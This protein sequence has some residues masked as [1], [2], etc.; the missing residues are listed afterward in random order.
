[1]QGRRRDKSKSGTS[2]GGGGGARGRAPHVP[3][4]QH[5]P[6]SPRHNP[7][8]QQLPVAP[9][10]IRVAPPVAPTH[11]QMEKLLF[12]QQLRLQVPRGGGGGGRPAER[13]INRAPAMAG[14]PKTLL[15]A[16]LAA[17][18]EVAAMH[19]VSGAAAVKP[20]AEQQ[21]TALAPEESPLAQA[22]VLEPKAE[23]SEEAASEA[24]TSAAAEAEA[25]EE[26]R[27]KQE[28]KAAKKARR[29]SDVREVGAAL[30]PVL[31]DESEGGASTACDGRRSCCTVGDF[32]PLCMLGQGAFGRVQL[33]RW[34]GD[35]R[36]YA[37][38]LVRLE[39]A[40]A[41][42]GAMEA[43]LTERRALVECAEASH[44]LLTQIRC[45]FRSR[46]HLH[47]VMP[48][49]QGGTLAALLQRQQPEKVLRED[50]ARFYCA[51]LTIALGHLHARRILFLDLK[52]ENV[53][54]SAA[55]DATLV[56]FGFARC[57]VDAAAGQASRITHMHMRGVR[58]TRMHRPPVTTRAHPASPAR[59]T[60]PG[61][62]PLACR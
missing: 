34:R 38:K 45:A 42:E 15:P 5:D 46:R 54:L 22:A 61:S 40:S 9:P 26:E 16:E 41:S 20:P 25:V 39:D 24:M 8:L 52:L 27:R 32:V 36:P 12:A 62:F 59:S 57:D 1:M 33:V 50:A 3:K 35:G 58:G 19:A 53:M 60:P 43:L 17:I 7:P 4:N 14:A 21:P 2:G 55:G 10:G 23:L 18:L 51:Q 28:R 47:L 13:A 29:L 6:M 44:P 56:D 30:L 37:M 49:L 48:F 31:P 11:Q